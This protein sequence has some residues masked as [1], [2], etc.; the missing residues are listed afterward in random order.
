MKFLLKTPN[1][2]RLK[3]RKLKLFMHTSLDGFVQGPNEWDLSFVTYDGELEK[4]AKDLLSTVDTVLWGRGTYLGMQDYWT[5]VP[6]NPE[7][8][9]HE[10]D[11]AE[12]INKTTKIVFSTTLEKA[13]WNNSRLVKSNIAEEITQL[14]Q[15]PGEDMIILGSPRFAHSLMQLGLID[16]YQITVSPVILGGGLPLF[17]ALDDRVKLKMVENKILDSGVVC[18]VYQVDN[19]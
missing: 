15:Q 1:Q 10:K 3:M 19:N 17:T 18:L 13:E 16:V 2:R 12:W 9:M 4:Y 8:S 14:K 7:A 11:H 5:S 6:S